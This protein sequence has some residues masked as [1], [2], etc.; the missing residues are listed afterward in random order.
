MPLLMH[1]YHEFYPLGFDFFFSKRQY[2]CSRILGIL[3]KKYVAKN[4][5]KNFVY[6]LKLPNFQA[7]KDK[8]I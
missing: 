8:K 7:P 2:T 5:K 6:K 3:F 4:E 1:N